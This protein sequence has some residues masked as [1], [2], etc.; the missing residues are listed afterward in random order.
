[1]EINKQIVSL[2][3]TLDCVDLI[4]I[5]TASHPE[6]MYNVFSSKT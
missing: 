2:N 4:D 5:Y 6:V 3:D 1:M